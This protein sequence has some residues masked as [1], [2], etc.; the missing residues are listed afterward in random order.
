[1]LAP[2]PGRFPG[3]AEFFIG[4]Q[5]G[6]AGIEAR[7][8]GLEDTEEAGWL[9]WAEREV[10]ILGNTIQSRRHFALQICCTWNAEVQKCAKRGRMRGYKGLPQ[11]RL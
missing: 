3:R 5:N 10:W 11:P 9:K 4:R 2:A 6:S 1:M 8:A 7:C